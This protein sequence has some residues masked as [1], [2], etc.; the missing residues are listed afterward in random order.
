MTSFPRVH[1]LSARLANQIAAG[2]VVERP[3]SV[4]KE[5]LEN[6]LDSGASNIRVDIE[7]GGV[8]LIRVQDDGCGIHRDDMELALSRHATSKIED[9]AD[10]ER[11]S[12]MGFRGEAL[13]SITSVSRSRIVSRTADAEA[14][15]RIEVAGSELEGA[16]SPQAHPPGTTIEVRD[17]FFNTPARRRFLR[18]ERTEL[19]HLEDVFKRV[20]LSRFDI[21]FSLNNGQRTVYKLRASQD[22]R[23]QE[24]RV[25]QLCGKAFLDHTLRIEFETAGM[26]LWGW[27]ATPDFARSQ[28][29]LQYFFLNGRTIRDRLVNHAVRQAYQDRL[30][31]GRHPAYVLFLEMAPEQVDVNVH[32]TKHEVRFREAR[33]VHDFLAGSLQRAMDGGVEAIR[34]TQ[35][36]NP[37]FSSEAASRS[38]GLPGREPTPPRNQ[39]VPCV[40]DQIA[41]YKKLHEP[42]Q[43]EQTEKAPCLLGTAL[44]ELYGSYILA[45]RG[46]K[47]LLIDIV[48][49]R[50]CLFR[51]RLS[52]SARE[53]IIS[54]QPLLLPIQIGLEKNQY[55]VLEQYGDRLAALG[56]EISHTG[57]ETAMVRQLPALLR[58]CDAGVFVPALLSGLA[59]QPVGEEDIIPAVARHAAR[60]VNQPASPGDLDLLLQELGPLV[61]KQSGPHIYVELKR[62]DLDKLF[63]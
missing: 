37:V 3:A 27:I 17:L 19:G 45:R 15:Y 32:P 35:T 57:P 59:Q 61:Q 7:G 40:R 26:R 22:V 36:D 60:A 29:D 24:R 54:S 51:E 10:L 6:S 2:E 58:D 9:L 28:T 16:L 13:A 4:L 47:L 1:R 44:A 56:F 52:V 31:Q 41:A 62:T 46:D 33:L 20:A 43:P 12:S 63:S 34:E 21:N 8:R 23:G 49:A 39:A 25:M 53:G 38:P 42:I 50:E 30:Y 5:L 11:L 14:G 48:L 18:S 55:A